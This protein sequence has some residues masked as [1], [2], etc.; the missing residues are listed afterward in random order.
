MSGSFS[1]FVSRDHDPVLVANLDALVWARLVG[2]AA[3]RF[4]PP[5]VAVIARGFDVSVGRL[6]V[7]LMVG[8]LAGL[9]SP[10]LGR[11]VDATNRVAAMAT[12]MAGVFLGIVAAAA[13][14][15]L[16]VLAAAMFVLSASKV[17][18]DTALTVWVNDRVPYG[19]RGEVV[20]IVETSWALGL[21]LGV[22]AMGLVTALVSWRAGFGLAAAALA[23][24]GARVL[25]SLPR[26]EAH[27]PPATGARTR[28]P[29][30]GFLIVG[31]FFFLLGAAQTVGIT[32]GPW[33]EDSFGFSGGAL[34]AVIAV[35][36]LVELA[37]SILSSR[38]VDRWGKETS[39]LRGV[40]LMGATCVVMVVA[41][42]SAPLAVPAVVAFF[43]GFEFAI[44]C[45]VPVAA[46]IVPVA[47]GAGLGA[48]LGAGTSGRALMSSVATNLY[49][50]TGPAGPA[51]LAA[52]MAAAA[53]V[54]IAAY[55]RS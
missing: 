43:L 4:A 1:R 21:F 44:V 47:T 5:F 49:D 28:I 46:A 35:S 16:V 39:A 8:D 42:G 6:G 3:Y 32:F 23:V 51:L 7:A 48:A 31:S 2:N 33:F 36:G 27:P 19:R 9:L 40:A 17:F 25:R 54:C 53:L 20:G 30:R 37:G 26:H 50:A 14:P 38:V 11:R 34:V 55:A 12:G 10:V 41:R 13:S 29:R 45:L 52:G 15:N 18:F 22:S 24:T